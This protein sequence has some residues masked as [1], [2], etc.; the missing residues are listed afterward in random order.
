M[1]QALMLRLDPSPEQRAALFATMER[2][3]EACAW[4]AAWAV[5]HETRSKWT[6]Q[7]GCYHDVRARFSLSAQL[8]VRAIAKVADALRVTKGVAPTFHPHGAV[9]YDSRIMSFKG[10]ERVSLKTLAGRQLILMRLGEYQRARLGSQR[11]E[12]DLILRDGVFYLAV[13]LETPEPEPFDVTGTLGVDLGIVN[14][15]ADSDGGLYSGEPV[16]ACRT[17]YAKRRSVLQSVG[18]RSARRTLAKNRRREARFRRNHNHVISKRIVGKAQDTKRQI[19]LEDLKGI[20]ARTTVRRPQRSRH[21]GW[22]FAQLRA[23]VEYKAAL[24][25]TPVVTVDPRDTSKTCA[26]CGHCARANRRRGQFVCRSCGHAAPADINAARVI[27]ARGE[28]MRPMVPLKAAAA[29]YSEGQALGFSGGHDC[30]PAVGRV[31]PLE[32]VRAERGSGAALLRAVGGA[33]VRRASRN[34][35]KGDGS[36]RGCVRAGVC[37]PRRC[38]PCFSRA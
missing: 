23:F 27:A 9:V 19:A 31:D 11:G 7:K 8:A 37:V 20:R 38:V 16:E 14:L 35:L 10:L 1:K 12:V 2:F 36:V 18:T 15:A 22:A 26:E 6:I 24:A 5:E 13:T 29:A 32:P 21:A 17:R 4:L 25:G 30:L 28:V 34:S 3:N 33:L